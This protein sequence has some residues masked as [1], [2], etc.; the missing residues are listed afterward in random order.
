MYL[1][2]LIKLKKQKNLGFQKFKNKKSKKKLISIKK[3]I[4]KQIKSKFKFYYNIN[5]KK[6]TSYIFHITK[7]PSN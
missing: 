3:Y 1:K 2:I 4:Y 5:E 7:L 6:L